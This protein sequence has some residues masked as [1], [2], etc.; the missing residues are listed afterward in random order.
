M[1]PVISRD[2]VLY[3]E[4]V[5]AWQKSGS[6]AGMLEHFAGVEWIPAFPLFLIKILVDC[7]LPLEV[8]GVGLPMVMGGM[9]PGLVYLIAQEVQDDERVSAI[10]SLLIAVNPAMIGLAHEVQRDMIYIVFCGWCIFFCLKGLLKKKLWPWIP[11]GIFFACAALTRYETLELVPIL[12][13][14][15]FI[16]GIKK[17]ISWKRICGQCTVFAAVAVL[18]VFSLVYLM[19][20]QDY[21]VHAHSQYYSGKAVLLKDQMT[22][23]K[24]R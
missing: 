19:G 10:A 16:F 24:G 1:D 7:G 23:D 3:L 20:V 12:G 13:G 6:Y 5:S 2:G 9:L 18:V 11:G 8:A 15:F 4:L 22:F 14:I 17:E 21:I